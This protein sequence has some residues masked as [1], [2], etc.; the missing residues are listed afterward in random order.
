MALRL[1][2]RAVWHKC[3]GE[4]AEM[5]CGRFGFSINIIEPASSLALCSRVARKGVT[6][7]SGTT[8]AAVAVDDAMVVVRIF[9]D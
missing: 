3:P 5:T 9:W 1:N 6:S 8:F 4:K 7:D 2:G